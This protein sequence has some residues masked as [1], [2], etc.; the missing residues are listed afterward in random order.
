MSEEKWIVGERV[1]L[2]SSGFG[3]GKHIVAIEAI[4][5][6]G[7]VKAK[8]RVFWPDGREWE[9]DHWHSYRMYKLTPELEA[10]HVH[11]QQLCRAL[12]DYDW[13]EAPIN[14]LEEAFAAISKA[15]KEGEM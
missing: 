1:L 12:K 6:G 4:T 15:E 2:E 11:R 13:R 14:V 9:G 7:K 8:G 3:G 10:E 5:R